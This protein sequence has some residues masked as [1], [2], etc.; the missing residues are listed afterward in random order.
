MSIQHKATATTRTSKIYIFRTR[1]T[2]E[3]RTRKS[4]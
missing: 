4:I 1:P 2:S 3:K